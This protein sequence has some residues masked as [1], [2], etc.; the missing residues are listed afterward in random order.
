M[1]KTRVRKTR[2]PIELNIF[3]NQNQNAAKGLKTMG[4]IRVI[5]VNKSAAKRKIFCLK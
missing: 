3:D 5:R 2:E 1:K 4:K